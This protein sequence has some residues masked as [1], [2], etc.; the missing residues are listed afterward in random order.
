LTGGAQLGR[1]IALSEDGRTRLHLTLEGGTGFDTNPYAVPLDEGGFAGDLVVRIRPGVAFTHP[2]SLMAFDGSLKVDYGFFP[3][4]FDR[5]GETG[6]RN[7]L[8]YQTAAA[9]DVV[10]N[11]GGMFQFALGD[12]VSFNSDPG[13]IVVGTTLTRLHNNLRAGVGF[14]PGG[15]TLSLRLSYLFDFIKWFDTDPVPSGLAGTGLLDQMIHTVSLRSDY[16]FLPK[17]GTFGEV[18][19][20]VASF[21]FATG[22]Q[23]ISFPIAALVGVMGA[24]TP[25]I[26]GI[27][28]V[29][30]SNPMTFD[31]QPSGRF[32]LQT[33]AYVGLMGQGEIRWRIASTSIVGGGYQRTVNPAPLYQYVTNNRFYA[34][35]AQSIAERV[36]LNLNVGYS[37][38]Q[39]GFEQPV[40]GQQLTNVANG[41]RLDGHLDARISIQY[42]VVEWFRVGVSNVTDWR[43]TNAE[44]GAGVNA[45]NLSFLR[46]QSLLTAALSY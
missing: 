31:D 19:F 16:R 2:G 24:F 1:G 14:R 22:P 46:N 3:G 43:L 26:S 21:P 40:S 11:R 9:G 5:P 10:V 30:Y 29:G 45:T 23:P 15:G 36:A 32:E 37:V 35:F 28:S 33:G 27:A 13:Q 7:F 6:T 34:A 8:L 20:G 39:F 18:R 38:L 44:I 17:T 42:A 41:D 4:L 12:T 25:K